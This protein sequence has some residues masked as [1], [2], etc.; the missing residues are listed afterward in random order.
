MPKYNKVIVLLFVIL[1]YVFPCL[2]MEAA[3]KW[4]TAY[5][6]NPASAALPLDSVPWN[7]YSHV[8]Q[9]CIKPTFS[10]GTPGIETTSYAINNNKT[11]FVN[12][13][14][15][16]GVKA[17]IALLVGGT[18]A[19][20]MEIDTTSTYVD[21]FVSTLANFVN[22]NNYDGIDID[23]ESYSSYN[24]FQTQFPDFINRLRD[25][26][27]TKIIT[28][29]GVLP[30]RNVYATIYDKVDQINFMCYDNDNGYYSGNTST[31]TWFNSCV[32]KG[33]DNTFGNYGNNQ[34][35]E[36]HLW[37][38]INSAAIP[39]GKIGLGLPFYGRIKQGLR[40]NSSDGV[41]GPE[42]E[43]ASGNADTNPRTPINYNALLN[44]IYWTDGIKMWDNDHKAP[45]LS[46]NV[47]GSA[48]DAFV[49]YPNQQQM[50]ESV[51]LMYEKSLGGIMVWALDAEYI[52]S[53][54]GDN[55]YPL[56]TA[57]YKNM[58]ALDTGI[59][60]AYGKPATQSST[61][62]TAVAGRAVDGNT[63]GNYYNNSVTHTGLGGTN[64]WWEVDLQGTFNINQIRIWNRT[65]S[66]PDRLSNFYVYILDE[67][68]NV[69]WSHL[70]APYPTP[71][72]TLVPGGEY[73]RYVRISGP[74]I[75]SLSEVQ[76][77]T[78]LNN[79]VMGKTA[80]QSSTHLAATAD[81]AVDGNTDGNYWN[82]SVTC[83]S[84]SNAWWEVDLQET[85]NINQ[86]NIWNRTDCD[87]NRL[88]NF[89]VYILDASRNVVWSH[90]EAPYPTPSV[91]LTPG[92][93]YGRYVKISCPN[94]L[95]LAEVQV[96]PKLNNIAQ[97]KT[98]TQSSTHLAATANLAVDGNTDGNYWNGSVTCTSMDNAWWQVDLGNNFNIGQIKIWNRTD[99]DID[100]LSN[101][102][103]YILDE[104]NALVWFNFQTNYPTPSTTLTP[105]GINGRYVKVF[106]PNILTLAEV[107][108][109]EY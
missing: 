64:A 54:S 61:Y 71:A 69:V 9:F 86:I 99:C 70:E 44:S 38:V 10:N 46:Y 34:S 81:L 79:I 101:Y 16:K 2:T 5:Y 90:L 25:A 85:F 72:V 42:Q 73:G 18:E 96:Y 91:M 4:R 56:S 109:I 65:D 55:R 100:R 6:F 84:M 30:L 14:H 17:L 67:S 62:S 103:V 63:D 53:Q 27:P 82:G 93:N 89:Y 48:N 26:M 35:Q 37:Y 20:A 24:I 107:Q 50:E 88:S 102:F 108:V 66:A 52:A 1:S 32:R 15:D 80:T 21:S 8:I 106:C 11:A 105:G 75:L 40:K 68:R 22:S 95:T 49:T 87:I 13:A 47:S 57:I 59:N 97:G 94:I 33:P 78:K 19:G 45:Y 92:G 43:Y 76:V 83:T 7:K 98:A 74:N 104:N 77:Y 36:E 60:V 29:A 12:A 28:V 39:A 51:M 31:Q 23:W 58:R 3:Q 41:T